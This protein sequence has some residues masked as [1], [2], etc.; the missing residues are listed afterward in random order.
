MKAAIV[1]SSE[2]GSNC[3]A[4]VRFTGG[5]RCPRWKECNYPE[6]AI[7]K[8]REPEI[9]HLKERLAISEQHSINLLAKIERLKGGN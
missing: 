6:K 4:P 5:S 9:E 3:W 8:A 1:K 7:C 2:L